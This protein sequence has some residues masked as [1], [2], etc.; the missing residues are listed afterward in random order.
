MAWEWVA[1]VV[2]GAVGIAGIGGTVW[3]GNKQAN[4]AKKNAEIQADMARTAAQIQAGTAVGLADTE[5][6]Q[7]RLEDAYVELLTMAIEGYDY[8]YD[9]ADT[10]ETPQSL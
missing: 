9:L 2:T 7:R 10:W 1:P 3:S 6:R 5:R 4:T 8:V